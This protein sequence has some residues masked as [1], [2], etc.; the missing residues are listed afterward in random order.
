[1][2]IG[3]ISHVYPPHIGGLE[4]YVYR[5]KQSLD[6]KGNDV[7]VYTTDM[8]TVNNKNIKEKNVIY[9]ESKISL[10]RNPISFELI[11]ELKQRDEDIYHIHGYEFLP[12][13]FATKILKDKPKVLTQHGAEIESNNVMI[14]LLNKVYHP[15]ARYILENMDM[16]IAL[17]NRDKEFL[18]KTFNLSSDK[19]VVIPNGVN[20]KD[21]ESSNENNTNFIIKYNLTEDSFKILF[22]GRLIETKNAHKLVNAVTKHIKSENIEVLIIGSG[23]VE[24]INQLK[25]TS[26]N[27]IHVLGEV[28]F[29]DLVAAYNVSDLLVQLGEWGEGMPTVILEAMA[30]GLPILTTVGGSISDVITEGENG[31]FI[32]VPVDEKELA[33]KIE[34]FMGFDSNNNK[35]AKANITK[36]NREFNWDIIANK[37]LDV[38][39]KVLEE[40]E[41]VLL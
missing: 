8:D 3:Q 36:V 40:Y 32:N 16:I 37:I 29:S 10:L 19:V 24:Y 41:C 21:L 9:C 30:C 27:R 2:K 1:M 5:L 26:D 25:E 33:E 12:C 23:D 15:F 22:V 17:G 4:N 13:L 18:L 6:N 28:N 31:L 7:T 38:Y 34:Y 35:M 39:N 11:R 20:V 14:Y